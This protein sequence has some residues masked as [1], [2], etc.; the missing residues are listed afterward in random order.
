MK[1]L[2]LLGMLCFSFGA[3]AQITNPANDMYLAIYSC[4]VEEVLYGSETA[5]GDFQALKAEREKWYCTEN[6]Y[7]SPP[8]A[9]NPLTFDQIFMMKHKRTPTFIERYNLNNCKPHVPI[10]NP[11]TPF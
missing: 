5:T 7:C 8:G 2:F 6:R 9:R 4:G 10:L 3:F 1:K 11:P